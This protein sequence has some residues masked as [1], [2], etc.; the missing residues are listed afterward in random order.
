MQPGCCKQVVATRRV[1]FEMDPETSR[2]GATW[3]GVDM[4][5]LR[6]VDFRVSVGGQVVE[7]AC[8]PGHADETL[9]GRDCPARDAQ[10]LR[11][12]R[13][14]ELLRD[15]RFARMCRHAGFTLVSPS[16]LHD[17]LCGGEAHAA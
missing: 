13:E 3:R 17:V 8:H 16:Q 6:N 14:L 10:F 9:L 7:L 4:T 11:R 5:G 2:W 1:V 12:P 15:A